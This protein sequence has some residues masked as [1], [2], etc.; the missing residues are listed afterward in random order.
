MTTPGGGVIA[1]VYV[2]VLPEVQRFAS[3][4]R[5][6]LRQSSRE[7][8]RIDREI[9]PVNQA[10][11][12]MARLATAIVPGVRL[13]RISLLA[14]GAHA[15]VGGILAVASA[16]ETLA[17]SLLVVP[18][19]G[20]AAASGVGALA[21]GLFGVQAAFKQF[22]KNPEKFQDKVDGL[23]KNAQKTLNVFQDLRQ[24]ITDFRNS[25][26]DRLFAGLDDVTRGLA[27]TILP[28]LEAHFGNLVDLVNGGAKDL[29]A[30]VQTGT[31]LRDVDTVTGNVELGFTRLKEA[32]IPAAT[33]FRDIVTV[34][35]TF[36]PQIGSEIAIVV[37]HFALW[38]SQLR[39]TGQLRDI[40]QNGID[41][42]KQLLRIIGNVGD[43]MHTIFD[44][45]NDSGIGFLD[46]LERLTENLNRFLNT[47]RGQN[48][49]TSFMD[50]AKGAGQALLPVIVALADLLFEHVAPVLEMIAKA[51]GP[52]VAQFFSALGDAITQAAPGI[53]V[54][55]L[56]FAQFVQAII[57]A[58]PAIAQLV[59]QLGTLIGILAG[60]LGP[61]IASLASS[62]AN[63]LTPIIS[64]LTAIFMFLPEPIIRIVVV[65]GSLVVVVATLITVI[66]GAQAVAG[67]F[68]G[69]LELLAKGLKKTEGGAT[70]LAGFLGGPWGFAIGLALTGLG[71][72]LSATEDNT[73]Q[74]A[75]FRQVA[76]SLNDTI[77]E[78][79][80]IITEN[81]RVKA[82]QQLE[83][84]HLLAGAKALGLSTR[85]LTNAYLEQGDSL[86]HVRDKL[87]KI[88]D[89]GEGGL[90]SADDPSAVIAQKLLDDLNALVGAKHEDAEA[91]KRENEAAAA[92]ISPMSAWAAVV[93]GTRFAIEGLTAAQLRSQQVQLDS[94]NNQIAYQNQLARTTAELAEGT[95]TLDL[96][97]QEGRDNLSALTSLTQLGLQHIADLQ[98]QNASYQEVTAAQQA[99][100]NQLLDLIGPFFANRDAAHA[101]L[102]QLGL[103]PNSVTVTILTNI[104]SVLSAAQQLANTVSHLPGA[105]FGGIGGHARGGPVKPGEW[106][107]VGEEG[108][109]LVRFGQSARIYSNDESE[110]MVRDVGDLD[111]M[112]SR[113]RP[114]VGGTSPS[115]ATTSTVIAPTVASPDVDVHVYIGDQE[116]K[117]M[118]R[119]EVNQ[120]D[121]QTRRLITSGSGT[122]GGT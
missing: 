70:G 45:A 7:L 102:V 30:F 90:F 95:K 82:A 6:S 119:V 17:G 88:I 103:I 117:D 114:D 79:N 47:T 71:L 122:R 118:V 36:L 101:F 51:V 54:F 68:S 40:I 62:I 106:T 84:E 59:A 105:I 93:D 13:A 98:A 97:T 96:N 23:S 37:Q 50:S 35:S 34:G 61:I 72:F 3:E 65:L 10:L 15:V 64:A 43:I 14:L 110:N 67:L 107:W 94:L 85:D 109:E 60:R 1:T 66:R 46:T 16:A 89:A 75:H 22:A 91:T 111:R 100:E 57:P 28:R 29:A 78:Q 41:T 4:L 48:L 76:G 83:D 86:D 74:M 19:L 20:V 39:A 33:A 55:A 92:G 11:Q 12:R 31:T 8:R 26:Q 49:L 9:E 87:Q 99:L 113:G 121:R 5:R 112:T 21:V 81:V 58:L 24:E 25:V 32:L 69:G 56:G 18:A 73:Q 115:S 2:R 42:F 108:P 116:L 104:G 27:D 52:A 63:I 120:R 44:A 80:G 53:K 38:I 77:R